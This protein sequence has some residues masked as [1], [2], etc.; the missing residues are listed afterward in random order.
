[1]FGEDGV[2]TMRFASKRRSIKA[3]LKLWPTGVQS[4]K[5]LL[6]VCSLY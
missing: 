4:G 2:Y 6:D 1:M 5:L 3:M